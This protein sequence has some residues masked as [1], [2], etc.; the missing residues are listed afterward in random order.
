MCEFIMVEATDFATRRK[1]EGYLAHK[2]GIE[3]LLDVD[4]KYKERPPLKDTNWTPSEIETRLWMDAN[5]SSTITE[6]TGDVSE[7]RDKSGH[8]LHYDQI[9]ASKQPSVGTSF[10]GGKSAIAFDGISHALTR[11]NIFT[12]TAEWDIYVMLDNNST[13][14]GNTV[15]DFLSPVTSC[16]VDGSSAGAAKFDGVWQNSG[17]VKTGVQLLDFQ[18]RTD[19]QIFRDGVSI[20]SPTVAYTNQSLNSL[21]GIGARYD[22]LFNFFTGSIGEIIIVKRGVVARSIVEGYMAWKWGIVDNLDSGHTYKNA[23]PLI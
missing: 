21:T 17:D 15:L 1:I 13:G 5:D 19:G 6:T 7:W 3:N 2:W 20:F 9:T 23:P 12:E 4:H 18:F 14:T 11:T 8:D 10:I 16:A 22:G